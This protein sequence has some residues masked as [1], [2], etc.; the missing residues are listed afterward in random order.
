MSKPKINVDKVITTTKKVL[1]DL[2]DINHKAMSDAEKEAFRKELDEVETLALSIL[3]KIKKEVDT[4][5][6]RKREI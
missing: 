1:Y 4:K 5:Y 3:K 2:R 6:T